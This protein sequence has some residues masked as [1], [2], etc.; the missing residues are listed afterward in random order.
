ML[1]ISHLKTFQIKETYK[2][3]WDSHMD[4]DNS[5]V[6]SF[7]GLCTWSLYWKHNMGNTSPASW[8]MTSTASRRTCTILMQ[9]RFARQVDL[10]IVDTCEL[11]SLCKLI[12][13]VHITHPHKLPHQWVVYTLY[14]IH[15]SNCHKDSN[16]PVNRHS[17][18]LYYTHWH[19]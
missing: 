1:R 8:I 15:M 2:I 16:I 10:P 4:R 3:T 5:V 13:L 11:S 14:H 6:K 18:P 17:I 19:L 12:K 9:S 7:R